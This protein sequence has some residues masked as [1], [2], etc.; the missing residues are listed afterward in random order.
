MF[1]QSRFDNLYI[2]EFLNLQL[3]CSDV[4]CMCLKLYVTKSYAFNNFFRYSMILTC[5]SL[6]VGVALSSSESSEE[7]HPTTLLPETPTKRINGKLLKNVTSAAK[8]LII[9]TFHQIKRKL[10]NFKN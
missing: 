5:C 2:N 9:C 1:C 7:E 3:I 4:R 8:L 6:T 10:F